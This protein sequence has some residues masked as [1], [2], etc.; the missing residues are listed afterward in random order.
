MGLPF[1]VLFGMNMLTNDVRN[2]GVTIR[3]FFSAISRFSCTML[4]P[5][6]HRSGMMLSYA[7]TVM[8]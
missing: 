7:I 5:S 4:C 2:L 1:I 6:D 3:F 8:A